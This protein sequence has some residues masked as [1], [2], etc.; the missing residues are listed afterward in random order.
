MKR[1]LFLMLLV[2]TVFATNVFAVDID[3]GVDGGCVVAEIKSLDDLAD[4]VEREQFPVRLEFDHECVV[5]VLDADCLFGVSENVKTGP[6]IALLWKSSDLILPDRYVWKQEW[7]QDMITQEWYRR[8]DCQIV[9][10]K[11]PIYFQA[12]AVLVPVMLGGSY[13]QKI[14]KEFSLNGKLFLGVGFI[15]T[16]TRQFNGSPEYGNSCDLQSG[17]NPMMEPN[18][19][20]KKSAHCFVA[21]PSIGVRYDT[22]KDARVGLDVGYL[23]TLATKSGF[24]DVKLDFSGFTVNLGI[25][26]K[27]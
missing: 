4:G 18:T 25:T 10:G 12:S 21:N 19:S 20:V 24:K 2:L 15:N 7:E 16:T 13:N 23:Y 3:F 8:G 22:S 14:T 27:I 1:L 5:A 26:V 9:P 11:H 17:S 6:R